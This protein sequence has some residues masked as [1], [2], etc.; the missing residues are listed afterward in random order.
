[1]QD[2]NDLKTLKDDVQFFAAENLELRMK[3]KALVM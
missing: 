3:I 1:V 2:E